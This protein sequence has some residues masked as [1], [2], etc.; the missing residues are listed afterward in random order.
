MFEKDVDVEVEDFDVLFGIK[1]QNLSSIG[2]LMIPRA[3]E[4]HEMLL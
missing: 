4:D 3:L 1:S 2:K